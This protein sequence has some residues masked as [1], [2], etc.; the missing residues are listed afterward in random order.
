MY[1]LGTYCENQDWKI[2]RFPNSTSSRAPVLLSCLWNK[3]LI[4]R[5]GTWFLKIPAI[6]KSSKFSHFLLVVFGFPRGR[7]FY[8]YIFKKHFFISGPKHLGCRCL[9]KMSPKRKNYYYYFLH[10]NNDHCC[11]EGYGIRVTIHWFQ[12]F[13]DFSIE[14]MQK[15]IASNIFPEKVLIFWAEPTVILE[16]KLLACLVISGQ[17][18]WSQWQ[19]SVWKGRQSSLLGVSQ[20]KWVLPRVKNGQLSSAIYFP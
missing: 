8:L 11:K 18:K 7:G 3:G 2:V 19:K 10:W 9:T 14:K 13:T 5:D 16:Q 6:I 20:T 12:Y 15:N 17:G 4:I 1:V